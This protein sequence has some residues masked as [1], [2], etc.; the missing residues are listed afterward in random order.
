MI[1]IKA[2]FFTYQTDEI[3]DGVIT[4]IPYKG[5]FKNK[6]GEESFNIESFLAKCS[7]ITKKDSFI[8]TFCNFMCLTDIIK[9]C[10]KFGYKYHCHQIW[11]KEPVRNWISWSLP[12]RTVEYILYLSKGNFKF[13]FRNGVIK[14]KVNRNNFG[15]SQLI[16]T[17]KNNSDVS[18]GMYSDI[19]TFRPDKHKCHPTQKPKDFSEMFSHIV[20]KDKYIIDP[21][22]GSGNLL[23]FFDK[24]IN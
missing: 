12:L 7:I 21:F 19:I 14:P 9:I 5:C 24:S 6:L 16:Q 17:S 8:I 13:D 20:G 15:N 23:S 11:N 22:V 3:Y 2:D 10:D 4:D 1:F 18:Y